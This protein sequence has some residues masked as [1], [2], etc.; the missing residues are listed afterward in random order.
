MIVTI[1]GEQKYIPVSTV[2]LEYT[3]DGATFPF[4]CINCGN[5]VNVIGGKVIK[6][7]PILEPSHQIPVINTCHTCKAK[8]VFQDSISSAMH[9]YVDVVV[10]PK[11]EKQTFFCY[12]SMGKIK[13]LNAIIEYDKTHAYSYSLHTAIK[14]PIQTKCSNDECNITYQFRQLS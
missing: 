9:S 2:T 6:I 12:L 14:L 3:A 1:K 7:T 10:A 13:S 11:Q 4:H 8:F 5:T